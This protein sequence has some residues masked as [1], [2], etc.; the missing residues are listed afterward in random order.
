M[1]LLSL[2]GVG[3]TI[4][5]ISTWADHKNHSAYKNF[6][7]EKFH[8]EVLRYGIKGKKGFFNTDDIKKIAAYHHI[9]PNKHGILPE[10]GW[11]KC[12]Q[13]VK[14]YANT[15]FDWGDFKREWKNTIKLQIKEKE[16][17]LQDPNNASIKQ[18]ETYKNMPK[19][20]DGEIMVL[21]YKHWHGIPKEE[22]L[23]RMNELYNNTFWGKMCAEPPILRDNPR[24]P[25]SHTEIWI[26]YC[27]KW[28]KPYSFNAKMSFK[29]WYKTCCAKLGYDAAL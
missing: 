9:R 8:Q 19:M 26:M 1:G 13:Y 20:T 15:P 7:K 27:Q 2:L 3:A 21:E 29:N 5:T 17:R 16:Q 23:K 22:H 4:A 10:N 25:N 6:N 14:T 11:E 18:Y 28:H 12:E 24:F